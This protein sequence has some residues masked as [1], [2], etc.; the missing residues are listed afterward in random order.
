VKQI[1]DAVL[2]PAGI[3]APVI[4]QMFNEE[5]FFKGYF[6]FLYEEWLKTL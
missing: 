1:K 3:L 4:E 2:A 5:E 6:H